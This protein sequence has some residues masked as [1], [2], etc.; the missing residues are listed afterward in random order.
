MDKSTLRAALDEVK[1]FKHTTG[2]PVQPLI[3][4]LE[5]LLPGECEHGE[6]KRHGAFR[7]GV[8]GSNWECSGKVWNEELVSAVSSALFEPD[9]DSH[10]RE[11]YD[12]QAIAVLSAIVDTLTHKDSI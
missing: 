10:H 11:F 4:A 1:E 8:P 12:R 2:L 6:T 3:D 5:K 7:P 9:V